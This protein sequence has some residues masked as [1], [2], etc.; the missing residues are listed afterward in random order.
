MKTGLSIR[1]TMC[2][3]PAWDFIYCWIPEGARETPF[4]EALPSLILN[5]QTTPQPTSCAENRLPHL[6]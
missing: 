6:R 1:A 3:C 5:A 4:A 2:V